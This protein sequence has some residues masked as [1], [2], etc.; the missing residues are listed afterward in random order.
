MSQ[1]RLRIYLGAA[2]G[3]GKT[4]AMLSEGTRR[5]QRGAD[6]VIG[7]VDDHGRRVIH[8]LVEELERCGSVRSE[9][10]SLRPSAD[11]LDTAAILV[12]NPEVVLVDDLATC[13]K[14]VDRLLG[15]GIDVVSTLRVEHIASLADVVTAALGEAPTHAVPDT[16]LRRADQIEL[17][18]MTPEAL[19]R[20]I[21]HGNVF[22]ADEQADV[23]YQWSSPE[24]LNTLRRHAL[25]WLADGIRPH[26]ETQT[27]DRVVVAVTGAK[28]NDNVI[29]RA[30]RLALR[31]RSDLVGV[32]ITDAHRG[33]TDA[34]GRPR[35]SG[36]LLNA[37]RSLLHDLGG[38][39]HEL[40][41]DHV[42]GALVAFARSQGNARLV[43]GASR[44]SRLSELTSGSIVREVIRL[45][46][47]V[48]VHVVSDVAPSTRPADAALKWWSAR[49]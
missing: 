41:D 38:S 32:H 9:L 48:E 25:I 11:A 15:A 47:D 1:G 5:Q 49:V 29:L 34:D 45:A 31:T 36:S 14:D 4:F 33:L 46:G 17:V 24:T 35:R 26:A 42:G 20:R 39:F 18:D 2:P 37:H 19:L 43:I 22:D 7:Q 3:V 10:P 40:A 44:R 23:V 30:A 27:G 6:V 16:F 28:G 8:A 21:A 12:R 13:W